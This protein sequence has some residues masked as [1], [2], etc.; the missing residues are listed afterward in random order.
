MRTRDVRYR[1]FITN[2]GNCRARKIHFVLFILL[3]RAAR[4]RAEIVPENVW[5][6]GVSRYRSKAEFSGFQSIRYTT[7]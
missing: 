1:N 4:R 5:L 7:V 2:P 3:M 6:V